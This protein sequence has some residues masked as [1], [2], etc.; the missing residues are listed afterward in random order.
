M[1]CQKNA[2]FSIRGDLYARENPCVVCDRMFETNEDGE[3]GTEEIIE[4]SC[5]ACKRRIQKEEEKEIYSFTEEGRRAMEWESIRE[6]LGEDYLHADEIGY[7]MLS[8]GTPRAEGTTEDVFR[9]GKDRRKIASWTPTRKAD[10]GA[11]KRPVL[12]RPETMPALGLNM[13]GGT[14]S[15]TEPDWKRPV[16]WTGCSGYRLWRT[17]LEMGSGCGLASGSRLKV[18]DPEQFGYLE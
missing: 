1:D 3:D 7:R 8:Q 13:N 15:Q 6:S 16:P 2:A 14:P 17:G 5:K 18:K 9:K 4:D 12:Q 10:E 11:A